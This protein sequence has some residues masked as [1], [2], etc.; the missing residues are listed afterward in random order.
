MKIEFDKEGKIKRQVVYLKTSF[1]FI[2][3][4]EVDFEGINCKGD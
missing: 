1:D 3:A 2:D 4:V